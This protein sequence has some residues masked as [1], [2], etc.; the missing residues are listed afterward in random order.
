MR[1]QATVVVADDGVVNIEEAFTNG[2]YA[3]FFREFADRS[4]DRSLARLHVPT[5]QA[6]HAAARLFRALDQEY[7]IVAQ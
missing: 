5:R 1:L 7:A 2:H 4:R 3:G 6:P